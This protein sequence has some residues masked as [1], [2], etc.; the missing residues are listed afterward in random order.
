MGQGPS[1]EP[2][3]WL[4][5]EPRARAAPMEV[6]ERRWD[7]C[8][9]VHRRAHAST[10]GHTEV[11]WA[12]RSLPWPEEP[13]GGE[14]VC[15]SAECGSGTARCQLDPLRLT[16][17][18]PSPFLWDPVTTAP[19]THPCGRCAGGSVIRGSRLGE[20]HG[21]PHGRASGSQSHGRLDTQGPRAHSGADRSPENLQLRPG[22]GAQAWVGG[23]GVP[24]G[25]VL[26]P[27]CPILGP[28]PTPLVALGHV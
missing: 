17:A 21:Q 18:Y 20:Q 3:Q 22:P 8:A 1:W 12:A 15:A 11:F 28:G 6:E 24:S 9:P 13:K 23:P 5:R 25:A 27:P 16:L 10:H 14:E 2:L 26:G 7:A 4:P 19:C